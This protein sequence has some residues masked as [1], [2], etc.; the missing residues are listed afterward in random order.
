MHTHIHERERVRNSTHGRQPAPHQPVR[1]STHGS[2]PVPHQPVRY[3]THGRQ[4]KLRSRIH[5]QTREMHTH[6]HTFTH[7]RVRKSTHGLHTAPRSRIHTPSAIRCT[8]AIRAPTS[9]IHTFTRR[10]QL[11][12]RPPPH[13]HS[14]ACTHSPHD[15]ARPPPHTFTHTHPVR[16]STHGRHPTS[17]SHERS[18]VIKTLA[19]TA[20]AAP[21]RRFVQEE[22]VEQLFEAA[23]AFEVISDA[24]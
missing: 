3:S 11:D 10:P 19:L 15:D 9:H 4:P 20:T 14:H 21:A 5:T 17:T 7:E 18:D 16:N 24:P 6:K 2:Q 8:A 12:A 1:Y 13:T 23:G 22:S